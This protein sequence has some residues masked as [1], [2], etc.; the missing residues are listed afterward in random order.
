MH[1]ILATVLSGGICGA[2]IIWQLSDP[3]VG[4]PGEKNFSFAL[5]NVGD[6]LLS[7]SGMYAV[8]AACSDIELWYWRSKL[9]CVSRIFVFRKPDGKG[10]EVSIFARLPD[11]QTEISEISGVE[12]G[13][14]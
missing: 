3:F 9:C 12:I 6:L 5:F 10:P 8:R 2:V 1:T 13:V 11:A 7:V 4:R 14:V